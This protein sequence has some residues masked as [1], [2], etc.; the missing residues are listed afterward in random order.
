MIH[1]SNLCLLFL[2]CQWLMRGNCKSSQREALLQKQKKWRRCE[3]GCFCSSEAFH[4]IVG[5]FMAKVAALRAQCNF[6]K[7]EI[8]WV[9]QYMQQQSGSCC[10][11]Q[12]A[13]PSKSPAPLGF[14]GEHT[15]L[16]TPKE[17]INCQPF[18]SFMIQISFHPS[19]PDLI[20]F[21]TK[22]LLLRMDWIQ[23]ES[24]AA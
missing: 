18:P 5:L 2:Y 6:Q 14:M 16:G 1:A 17:L 7:S 10:R 23:Y 9:N 19:F 21:I 15:G 8:A 22:R 3:W 11:T 13:S 20:M 4:P 12:L 24:E